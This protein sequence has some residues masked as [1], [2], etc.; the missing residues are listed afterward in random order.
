M[1]AGDGGG[2]ANT[3]AWNLASEWR[4]LRTL[5]ERQLED[6]DLV[7]IEEGE[8]HETHA[9]NLNSKKV[10]NDKKKL[11]K[12]NKSSKKDFF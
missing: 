10:K 12:E 3:L 11:K 9:R 1:V 4:V 6:N 7:R 2:S 5:F 8:N